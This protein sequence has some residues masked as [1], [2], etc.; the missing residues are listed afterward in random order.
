MGDGDPQNGPFWNEGNFDGD[1]DTDITDFNVLT[2]NFPPGGYAT[3]AIP[4][5]TSLLLASLALILVGVSFRLSK[6]NCRVSAWYSTPHPGAYLLPPQ[7]F[8]RY[9]AVTNWSFTGDPQCLFCLPALP[10]NHVRIPKPR[11]HL[12]RPWITQPRP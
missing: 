7:I 4:E 2:A 8:A 6:N 1:D 5:P 12:K 3:S 10:A 9:W 11:P